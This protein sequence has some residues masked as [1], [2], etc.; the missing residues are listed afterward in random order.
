MEHLIPFGASHG[1]VPPADPAAGLLGGLGPGSRAR[2]AHDADLPGA[3]VRSPQP[4]LG[5]RP[6]SPGPR[7]RGQLRGSAG[8]RWGGVAVP[9]HTPEGH[10]AFP[11]GGS[12]GAGLCGHRGRNR[13]FRARRSWAVGLHVPERPCARGGPGVCGCLADLL[14]ARRGALL[15]PPGPLRV[16]P[17]SDPDPETHLGP[18][19]GL[20]G[21]GTPPGAAGGGGAHG[22]VSGDPP[23]PSGYRKVRHGADLCP[24]PGLPA[25]RAAA[26]YPDPRALPLRGWA[27]PAL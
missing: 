4:E 23:N 20:R 7:L 1:S 25:R 17:G 16:C 21:G 12:C 9:C 8:I 3:G 24:P 13:L 18:E 19:Q 14:D 10:R 6:G 2:S 26:G 15:H 22:G 5:H 27:P 11:G